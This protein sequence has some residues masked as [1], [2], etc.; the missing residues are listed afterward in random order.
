MVWQWPRSSETSHVLA[1]RVGVG[2]LNCLLTS[3]RFEGAAG[4]GILTL[5]VDAGVPLRNVQ[6]AASHADP[7][8]H[9]DPR[10][11]DLGHSA[12]GTGLRA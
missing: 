5:R 10:D 2:E 1:A 3:R 4:F 9:G 8:E 11:A 6:K 12:A 7:R